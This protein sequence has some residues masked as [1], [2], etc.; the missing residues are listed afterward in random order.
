MSELC[1][2]TDNTAGIAVTS[3]PSVSEVE[4][5]SELCE[6]ADDTAAIAVTPEPSVSEV[7]A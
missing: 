1:E 2:R 7:Q 4:A 3:E 5:V 6:R